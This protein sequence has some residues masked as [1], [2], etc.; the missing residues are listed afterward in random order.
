METTKSRPVI[1]FRCPFVGAS[2]GLR[3]LQCARYRLIPRDLKASVDQRRI[4]ATN[5]VAV[6]QT[7]HVQ[8]HNN[9]PIGHAHFSLITW[10][11]YHRRSEALVVKKP[12]RPKPI[13]YFKPA[14]A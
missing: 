7:S 5:V 2:Y 8:F 6:R 4:L 11:S 14:N 9:G 10:K 12:P 3:K 13:Q 1:F